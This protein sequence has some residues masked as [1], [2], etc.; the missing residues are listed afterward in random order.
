MKDKRV[1]RILALAAI[2]SLLLMA[3]PSM[4]ALAAET[5]SLSLTE[6][7]IG[8][9]VT[10]S[11]SGFTPDATVNIY[12]SGESASVGKK[13]DN[14]VINYERQS[15]VPVGDDGSFSASFEVPDT[16]TDGDK[17]EAVKAGTNYFYVTYY[18]DVIIKARATFTVIAAGISLS[19]ATGVAET[20][21]KI[22]GT[23]FEGSE[24]ITITY[25][26]ADIDIA[27]GNDKTNS[28]GGFACNIVIPKSTAGKHSI[29]VAIGADEVEAE[30]TVKP[31]ITISPV[32][33]IIGNSVKVTGTGFGGNKDVT[34]TFGGNQVKTGETDTY[35]SFETSFNVPVVEAGSFD[36]ITTDDGNTAQA[37]FTITTNISLSQVTSE[38]SPG[39]IGMEITISGSGFKPNSQIRIT[40]ASEPVTFTTT[41]KGDGSFSYTFKVP[42][43]EHGAHTITAT[44]GTN[45]LKATFI[46]ESEAPPTPELLLPPTGKGAKSK[47]SF[48]WS[49]VDDTSTPV[50]YALQIALDADF[51]NLVLERSGLTISG[52]TLTNEEKLESTKKEA[53]YYWRVRAVDAASNASDWTSSRTFYVSS[54]AWGLLGLIG[55]GAVLVFFLGFWAG[56]RSRSSSY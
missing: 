56:R 50:T 9:D 1:F 18:G 21:V 45:T 33:G 27:S 6:G 26:G 36:V 16:L 42:K 30:F 24:D 15:G 28:A 7:K 54:F 29:T 34:I 13:I 53:P 48:D 47:A 49:D 12:F 11:G 39:H 4:P 55:A 3:I 43:S 17:D 44:D 22:T 46:M 40:Y 2:F 19:P 14:D 51:T 41:S 8:T 35:G 37:K 52:Y 20:S 25:D 32:S 5:T 31:E 38:A 23:H 10:V